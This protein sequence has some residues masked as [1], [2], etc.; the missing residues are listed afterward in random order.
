MVRYGHEVA[1]DKHDDIPSKSRLKRESIP[2]L[3]WL[4]T[5]SLPT[6]SKSDLKSLLALKR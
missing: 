4:E 2:A 1:Q 6:N 5:V 3:R